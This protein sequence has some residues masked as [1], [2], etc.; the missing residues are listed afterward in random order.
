M[1]ELCFEDARQP[2][3]S[4]T[5]ILLLELA[6]KKNRFIDI[7]GNRCIKFDEFY[8]WLVAPAISTQ[9]TRN[10]GYC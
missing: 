10:L 5:S 1:S 9:A 4:L 8:S 2:S 7:D 6:F 3:L